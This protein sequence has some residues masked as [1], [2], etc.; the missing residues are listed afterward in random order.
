MLNP[1]R[2]IP[3]EHEERPV[4]QLAARF[5]LLPALVGGLF[6]AWVGI[7]AFRDLT[8]SVPDVSGAHLAE[9]VEL[10]R[11]RDLVPLAA[12]GAGPLHPDLIVAGTEPAPGSRVRRESGVTIRLAEAPA[13][14]RVPNLI[15]LTRQQAIDALAGTRF[16]LGVERALYTDAPA[17]VIAQDPP[18]EEPASGGLIDVLLSLGPEP[19]TYVAPRLS[20]LELGSVLELYGRGLRRIAEIRYRPPEPGETDAEIV[21]QDPPPGEPLGVE[22]LKLLVAAGPDTQ[23]FR[24]LEARLPDGPAEPKEV[25]VLADDAEVLRLKE[26]PGV[27]LRVPVPVAAQGS[28]VQVSFAG[29]V[30]LEQRLTA[31]A[32]RSKPR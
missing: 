25:V 2:G 23:R 17:G 8:V 28:R 26:L 7:A 21:E 24:V 10:M 29:S 15:G 5:C 4:S 27:R 13:D 1:A 3:P 30:I 11:R 14:F 16:S 18:S 20:G 9:A 6:L 22:G 19:A 32:E 12:G 31:L